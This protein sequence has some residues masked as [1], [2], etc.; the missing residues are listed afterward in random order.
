MYF[1]KPASLIILIAIFVLGFGALTGARADSGSPSTLSATAI[2]SNTFEAAS[3]ESPNGIYI[4][5]LRDPALSNY[6]G[7]INGLQATSPLETQARRLDVN[8]NSSV[9]YLSYLDS[10]HKR[11]GLDAEQALGHALN[12]QHSYQYALNGMALHLSRA[13]A[14]ILAAMPDVLAVEP[15]SVQTYNTD[16]GPAWIGAPAIWDGSATGV[17]TK[18]EGIIIGIMDTGIN[19]DH[20]SFAQVGGDGY[21]H[22]NPTGAGNYMGWCNPGNPNYDSN[23]ECNN[24][25]IGAWD[26]ADSSQGE[27]NGPRDF[28]GHG[29]HT[30]STSAGNIVTATLYA[31]TTA[32][33]ETISGVAPH[34]NIIIYDVCGDQVDKDCKDSDLVA[35]INQAIIDNV[36]VLNESIGIGGNAFTGSKQQAYLGAMNA[37][38]FIVRAAGND[39]PGASM[40]GPEPV[41]TTSVA[42]MT[43]NR[44]IPNSLINLTGGNTSAPADITGAGFTTGYGPA[45][46]VYAGD[47]PSGETGTPELCGAGDA[48]SFTSP[49]PAN[50]FNGE[51][52]VCDRGTYGR[53]E[54]GANVLAAGAG[55]YIL[56]D[57]GGGIVSDAHELPGVHI[58]MSDGDTLKTWLADGASNHMG[59]IAGASLDYSASNGDVMAGFSSRGP[60]VIDVIKPDVGAPGSAIW[61][62][63][64][65]NPGGADE[66]A[67][68]AFLSGTSM[69]SPHVAG[70]GALMVALHPDWTPTEIRSALM[71]TALSM[72]LK[73]E[74]GS[75][76]TDAFDVGAGR[77]DVSSAAASGLIMDE[78]SANF[79]SAN[80][81]IGG[82]PKTLNL[83]SLNDSNCL[84]NC[85]WSRSVQ[86]S[87]TI[88]AT[89]SVTYTV[90]S[91]IAVTVSPMEFVLNPGETQVISVTVNT[92]QVGGGSWNFGEISMSAIPGGTPDLYYNYIPAVFFDSDPDQGPVASLDRQHA[93][94][95]ASIP[96]FHMPIA[97][98]QP[99][100]IVDVDPALLE[101]IQEVSTVM[102]YTMDIANL[103]GIDLNW[104][105]TENA[106]TVNLTTGDPVA[107]KTNKV[108]GGDAISF[109]LD[110]GTPENSIGVGGQ[111]VWLNQFTPSLLEFPFDLEQVQILWP[112]SGVNSDDPVN[113][114]VI[115]PVDLTVVSA[116]ANI[117]IAPQSLSSDQATNTSVTQT[118]TISNTG[119][120]GLNWSIFEDSSS[121]D[122]MRA[123][124]AVLLDQTNNPGGTIANSQE[125]DA[126]NLT[127]TNQGA[128][129]SQF[130]APMAVGSSTKFTWMGVTSMDQDPRL[131]SM[132]VS[133]MIVLTRQAL[134][135]NPTTD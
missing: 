32:I 22:I 47:Y 51:I 93:S 124:Q 103:G 45:A 20:P 39:G 120:L 89:W 126:A 64:T 27:S 80:P 25:L 31:P 121:S 49:W 123:I 63:Y 81:N 56:V 106:P 29:S 38:I 18:G 50:T 69:S 125:Y 36:D 118:L 15:D 67:E 52:V 34:A 59:T 72:G 128:E 58:N 48:L 71:G 70:A 66:G 129:T 6:M 30:A 105:L 76:T 127:F 79:T 23:L 107:L 112:D 73:K 90:Q 60:G 54:K 88:S 21:V 12:I 86:S 98:F 133:I 41:W 97:V 2:N 114:L 7:G 5:Q 104:T 13:D 100:P 40:V 37:G 74:D 61:A 111:F 9:A 83:A 10:R 96:D 26:Y 110:D 4:V 16:V 44:A 91:N 87:L 57:N 92:S 24:K 130:R 55:G 101:I 62:A 77:I 99:P 109:A 94:L 3:A 117:E 85:S 82:D 135:Q 95:G 28:D 122:P 116:L 33:T 65:D 68:Y 35:A 119:T 113:P 1:K 11:F 131:L 132:C 43:H 19:L 42:A 108:S 75:T 115:V 78:T 14:L 46:I 53:V 134:W 102:T 84:G 17:D 8:S